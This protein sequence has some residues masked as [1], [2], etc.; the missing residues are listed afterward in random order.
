MYGYTRVLKWFH[1]DESTRTTNESLLFFT[2]NQMM[3]NLTKR[4]VGASDGKHSW[5]T[6][7]MLSKQGIVVE[8]LQGTSDNISLDRGSA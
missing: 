5:G 1:P 3:E 8:T 6:K 4:Q 2:L 7:W